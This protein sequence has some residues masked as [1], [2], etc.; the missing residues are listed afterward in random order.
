[1]CNDSSRSHPETN[2]ELSGP[3]ASA[4]TDPGWGRIAQLSPVTASH[5]R[6]V[7]SQLPE[8]IH[9]PSGLYATG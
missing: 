7:L 5:K 9:R 6:T 1:M 8:A 4:R 3:K 2:H